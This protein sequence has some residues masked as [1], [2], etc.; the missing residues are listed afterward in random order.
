MSEQPTA[1]NP[2]PTTFDLKP[3]YRYI[4]PFTGFHYDVEHLVKGDLFGGGDLPEAFNVSAV[5][6][7]AIFCRLTIP[8]YCYY[9][10]C[11]QGIKMTVERGGAPRSR[12]EEALAR[13]R[14][15]HEVAAAC[16]GL[17]TLKGAVAG[18]YIKAYTIPTASGDWSKKLGLRQDA[19]A[20]EVDPEAEEPAPEEQ[21]PSAPPRPT[22]TPGDPALMPARL[23]I[24]RA[25]LEA[26]SRIY[27]PGAITWCRERRPQGFKLLR[28]AENELE[29]A[30]IRGT[31]ESTERASAG[32]QAHWRGLLKAFDEQS[33]EES[34]APKAA[35]AG[36][37]ALPPALSG[38][39]EVC[40]HPEISYSHGVHRCLT[41]KKEL[42]ESEVIKPIGA[43]LRGSTLL[44][45]GSLE[46]MMS[47]G[48]VA[49][50]PATPVPAPGG[51]REPAPPSEPPVPKR[52]YPCPCG[53]IFTAPRS[54]GTHRKACNV[55][56]ASI[57]GK[58]E[59]NPDPSTIPVE[60]LAPEPPKF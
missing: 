58:P 49:E 45:A 37:T 42:Q 48:A 57:K 60:E 7:G 15:H 2:T 54:L 17:D 21:P 56:K 13:F 28:L 20:P 16:Y 52:S 59:G 30:A 36:A 9:R 10:A 27:A 34:A 38:P 4:N 11:V 46:G 35:S 29:L 24:L 18:F 5:G 44:Y 32:Y 22:E 55:Y 19:A 25:A 53:D 51:Q 23:L 8:F 43:P 41:C 47:P 33:S 50:P 6:E 12:Y 39:G 40:P 31:V 1:P 26:V 14:A 3:C